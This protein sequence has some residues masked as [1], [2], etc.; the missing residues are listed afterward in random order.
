VINPKTILAEWVTALQSCPNL[1]DALGGDG[2]SIQFYTENST[3]FGQSTQNNIRLAILSM[4]P[5]SIMIVWQGSGPG[6][7]GSALV[8]THDFSLYLRAPEEAAIGYEDIFHWIVNDVPG[9]PI[10]AAPAN[11]GLRMLHTAIDPNC[12]P[13]DFYLPSARRNTVVISA[14][15]TTFEYFEVPVRLIE[16]FNP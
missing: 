16:S 1:V 11:S 8:F 3:V 15:G 13:M 7:L 4:P 12:E 5:G 2:G 9:S 6:R 14:D 10:G